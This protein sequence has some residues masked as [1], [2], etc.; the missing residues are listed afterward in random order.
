M[1]Y[2][3]CTADTHFGHQLM[4]A[5]TAWARPFPY[6]RAMGEALINNWNAVVKPADIVCHLGNFT[7]G[8][9]GRDRVRS[10]S[11]RLMGRKI[12]IPGDH[13]YSKCNHVH[14]VIASLGWEEI[15]QHAEA[16]PQL[17]TAWQYRDLWNAAEAIKTLEA[18]AAAYDRIAEATREFVAKA[19]A[20]GVSS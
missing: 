14:P 7:F 9:N 17:W 3:T 2:V 4:P 13:D 11:S 15:A 18:R 1:S 8:L 10:I 16:R 12:L 5:N 20:L 6:V 19:K